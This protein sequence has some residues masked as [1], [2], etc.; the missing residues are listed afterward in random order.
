M[1]GLIQGIE[2]KGR[3]GAGRAPP[4]D[5]PAREGVNDTGD[6]DK[7]KGRRDKGKVHHPQRIGAGRLDLAVD[8]VLGARRGRIADRR[9]DPLAPYRALKS[10]VLHQAFH[11][12]AGHLNAAASDAACTGDAAR[13]ALRTQL[14]SVSA[15]HPNVSAIDVKAAPSESAPS[16]ASSSTWRKRG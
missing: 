10:H 16:G 8:M 3:H 6:I 14:R 15:E 13:S 7:P 1:Q 9:L 11:R 2:D 5:D 12:A 4:A